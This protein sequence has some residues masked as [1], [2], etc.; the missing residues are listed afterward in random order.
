MDI[1]KLIS[2]TFD[3]LFKNI[4]VLAVS[5]LVAYLIGGVTL[6]ILMGPMMA[7]MVL[8]CLRLIRGEAAEIGDVFKKFDKF[9]PTLVVMIIGV[10][11]FGVLI[12]INFIP[13]LGFLICLA[14]GPLVGAA[15]IF[16]ICGIVDKDLDFGPAIKEAIER[17][18]AKILE[19]WLLTVIFGVLSGVGAIACGIGVL[20]TLPIS[21][22][23]LTLVYAE[24]GEVSVQPGVPA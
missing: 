12:A 23:G 17:V 3:L 9:V 1:G 19:T 7:G 2:R 24:G 20:V 18:K 4:L 16:A 22:L 13:I 8:I 15:L 10:V 14:A 5:M 6:Y 11:A 21:V